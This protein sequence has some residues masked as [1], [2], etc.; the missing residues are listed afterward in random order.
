MASP[1]LTELFDFTPYPRPKPGREL[2]AE[3]ATS[4][5][6]GL[7]WLVDAI[8]FLGWGGGS[9]DPTDSP[10]KR[11]RQQ[12]TAKFEAE[13][14]ARQGDDQLL[15]LVLRRCPALVDALNMMVTAWPGPEATVADE[16]VKPSS[17]NP[18]TDGAVAAVE[19][20]IGTLRAGLMGTP[21]PRP[22]LPGAS[23][24]LLL[25]RSLNVD[26]AT[27]VVSDGAALDEAAAADPA[28]M[29]IRKRLG[30]SASLD[31]G[32]LRDANAA[33]HIVIDLAAAYFNRREADPEMQAVLR[34]LVD[35][36]FK[37][38]TPTIKEANARDMAELQ[39]TVESAYARVRTAPADLRE[40]L[41]DEARH[42]FHNP[43]I[44]SVL[45]QFVIPV[46]DSDP[47]ASRDDGEPVS[48]TALGG[49]KRAASTMVA[50]V[51]GDA[52][53]ARTTL[54]DYSARWHGA[55]RMTAFGV[56]PDARVRLRYVCRLVTTN[57][58]DAE[59]LFDA[60]VKA[61]QDAGW[62]FF[63]REASPVRWG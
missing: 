49:P 59:R 51:L 9:A 58:E 2:E 43:F 36:V 23:A 40:V 4:G 42:F 48:I 29:D 32:L 33:A 1:S 61:S 63:W 24:V 19:A 11:L 60:A 39:S 26:D 41:R 55:T 21:Q 8:T 31:D 37:I 10:A 38:A 16:L 56:K 44:F 25:I 6:T 12:H 30:A 47:A 15:E 52:A 3:V 18:P 7:W 50:R 54:E 35:A 17:G 53:P 57:D 20:V 28:T 13:Y 27:R 45:D 14:A 62:S 34:R 5:A 46:D 22:R